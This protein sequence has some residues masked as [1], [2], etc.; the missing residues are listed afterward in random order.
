[1]A[2]YYP[3]IARAVS[4]LGN[5]TAEARHEL[6]ERARTVLADRL[7]SSGADQSSERRALEMA[8]QRVEQ[9]SSANQPRDGVAGQTKSQSSNKPIFSIGLFVIACA[10]AVVLAFAGYYGLSMIQQPVSEA[11]ST[12]AVRIN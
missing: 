5:N 6:Y 1:M 3:L 4:R 11:F 8:I 12:N 9:D 2:D 10:V 7:K